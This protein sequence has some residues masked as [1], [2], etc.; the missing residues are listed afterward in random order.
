L[1]ALTRPSALRAALVFVGLLLVFVLLRTLALEADPPARLPYGI[2]SRELFAEGA[3]KAH[4]AR[5]YALFGE[6]R[7]HPADNYQFWRPQAPVWVY[8]LAAFFRVFGVSVASVRAHSVLVAVLGFWVCLVY[9]KKQLSSVGLV[10]FGLLLGCN[11]FY[12]HYTRAGL[13]EPMVNLF[14]AATVF[15]CYRALREPRWLLVAT[16]CL[17]LGLFSKM[18]GLF[19]LPML[20]LCGF[21][22]LRSAQNVPRAEK[23]AVLV[24]SVALLGAAAWYMASDAYLQRATWTVAHMAYAK[25]GQQDIDTD[26]LEPL[27]AFGHYFSA[28]RWYGRFFLLFPV[29]A[30]L[31]IPAVVH[32]LRELWRTRT[33]NW[34]SLTVLW[35]VLAHASLQLT[36]LLDLRFYLVLF[37]P[38]ALLGARGLDLWTARL[39]H[40]RFAAPALALATIAM[41]LALDAP[42]Q[43]AWFRA[44]TYAVRDANRRVAQLIGR[45]EDAVVVGMWAPWLTLATPYKFYVVRNYFN[46][47][48]Q[49]LSQLGVTHLLLAPGDRSGKFVQQSFPRQFKSKRSLGS[50]RVYTQPITLYELT[51]PLS[52]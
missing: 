22:S 28:E 2:N 48:K 52:R 10:V 51:E 35:L 25:D 20:L 47:S 9:G 46:V 33:L 44:R 24:G 49:A 18:S 42:R 8:S 6:W 36:P 13:I 30:P 11:Y 5:N 1:R 26:K 40:V 19:L 3:A 21:V 38:V 14:A 17:L 50:F 37:P 12:V 4:E 39:K 23:L 32:S 41:C 34:D 16:L 15:S 29:A 7:T 27:A 43:I 45:R 31:A